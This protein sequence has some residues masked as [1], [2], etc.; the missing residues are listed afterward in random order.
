MFAK[1]KQ[2]MADVERLKPLADAAHDRAYAEAHKA[3]GKFDSLEM[4]DDD[5]GHVTGY[6]S[7][8][9]YE[10]S[11]P[12]QEDIAVLDPSII[13]S[14]HAEFDPAHAGKNKLMARKGK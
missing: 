4:Y 5:I 14:V 11:N 7:L 9:D 1:G 6:S 10:E 8:E 13:R 3:A 12:E 2:I